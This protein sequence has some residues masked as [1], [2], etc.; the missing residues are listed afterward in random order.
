MKSS[1]VI[2][3]LRTEHGD[4]LLT[5]FRVSCP[6]VTSAIEVA[7][8]IF[9]KNIGLPESIFYKDGK[10]ND[11]LIWQRIHASVRGKSL[12]SLDLDSQLIELCDRYGTRCPL[13]DKNKKPV[14]F[15]GYPDSVNG[16]A[17]DCPWWRGA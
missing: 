1:A 7:T 3:F 15:R 2:E 10:G 6:S 13:L 14:P 12:R 17:G 4:S 5:T 16:P 9:A 8:E 11:I